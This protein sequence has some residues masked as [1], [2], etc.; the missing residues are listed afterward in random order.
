M[1]F[2]ILYRNQDIGFLDSYILLNSLFLGVQE[3]CLD[4][5]LDYTTKGEATYGERNEVCQSPGM[6]NV[7]GF[8]VWVIQLCTL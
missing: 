1:D 3:L 2:F 6:F 4:C 7:N 8:Y 5:P